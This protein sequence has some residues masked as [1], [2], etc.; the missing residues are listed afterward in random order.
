MQTNPLFLNEKDYEEVL[1]ILRTF[2]YKVYAYGSRA[3]GN[4]K[5]FSDIDLYIDKNIPDEMLAH[6]REAFDASNLSV[7]VDIL[8]SKHCSPEFFE[9]IKQDLILIN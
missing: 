1:K 7:K 6:L 9:L 2:P 5:K 3:R 4:F 8:T